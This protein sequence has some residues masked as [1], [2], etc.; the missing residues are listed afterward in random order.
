MSK[1]DERAF[2]S[3]LQRVMLHVIKWLSLPA[4]RSRSWVLSIKNGRREMKRLKANNPRFT[5]DF[6]TNNW[7]RSF[8]K[9]K[10]DAENEMNQKSSVESLTEKQVVEDEYKLRDNK[11]S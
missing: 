5:N 1:K 11:D 6:L 10:R 8:Q 7:E 3:Q 9:A 2:L 4:K